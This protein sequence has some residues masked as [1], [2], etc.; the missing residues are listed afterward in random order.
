MAHL[1]LYGKLMSFIDPARLANRESSS[2]WL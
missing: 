2:A 1:P